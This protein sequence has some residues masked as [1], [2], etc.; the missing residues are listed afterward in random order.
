MAADASEE[1]DEE[2]SYHFPSTTAYL[3]TMAVASSITVLVACY[4]ILSIAQPSTIES[5]IGLPAY[6]VSAGFPT[7]VFSSY[8]IPPAATKEPQPALFDP[9]L[10]ITY[11]LNLTNPDTI[12]TTDDDPIFYPQPIVNVS[13]ATA[14]ALVQAAIA[15]ITAIIQTP[16]LN[17]CTKCQDALAVAKIVAQTTPQSVPNMLVQLCEKFKFASNSSCIN[18][19]AAT[20]YG[21][22]WTQVLAFATVQGLDG[23]YICNHLSSTFCSQP[24][25]LKTNTTDLFPKPKPANATAP[26]PS[27]ERVKVLHLSDFLPAPL[28]GAYRCDTPYYLGLAALQSI[29]PLTGTSCADPFAWTIYTGDLVSHDSQNQLSRAYVEYAEYS[30]YDMFKAYIGSPVFAV[31][32]NHDSNPEAIDAPYSEPDGLG[33]QFSWNY[34]HLAGLWQQNGWINAF[35]ADEARVHYGAYSVKNQYGLRIITLNTDFWYKSNFLNYYNMSNPDVS[36]MQAFLIQELQAAEDAGE[37]VWILGHVLTGWDGTNPLPNPTDLFY[38]IVDRYSPHVIANIFFGHT[39]EDEFM[40]Y[41]ANN[42]SDISSAN[43]LT[44]GWIGPSVTP[45]TNLNS[46]FRMYE[47]DTASFDIYDA[48]TWYANVSSFQTLDPTVTGP[49]YEFEYSTRE[50]YDISWP[51]DAPLNATYWHAVTEAM[52]RNIE[53]VSTFNTLEGKTSINSP[54]CTNAACQ[55]A[56]IC[57]MR[58]GS[59]ALGLSCPKGLRSENHSNHNSLIIIMLQV[60]YI[61]I[62]LGIFLSTTMSQLSSDPAT[63][64][65]PIRILGSGPS[66]ILWTPLPPSSDPQRTKDPLTPRYAGFGIA[67]IARSP[68]PS[69]LANFYITALQIQEK[70]YYTLSENASTVIEHWICDTTPGYPTPL[71][72]T[73]V[74]RGLDDPSSS[75]YAFTGKAL[76]RFVRWLGQVDRQP[77]EWEFFR[78][79]FITVDE[80]ERGGFQR[81]EVARANFTAFRGYGGGGGGGEDAVVA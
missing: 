81:V 11:P 47:V 58:S 74:G 62:A 10:N 46:G 22:I 45:L 19:Y 72:V 1:E 37:R 24:A 73:A 71:N 18:N 28:Y 54:T 14:A 42:A 51:A 43:A 77:R 61:L 16:G 40:I 39:H 15:N 6:T 2:V 75:L 66:Q 25:T 67:Y 55:K 38:Q 65:L 44:T 23:R 27:G 50:T 12:P 41:Y 53:L 63:P 5:S 32:G 13:S 21:A 26:K 29:G 35:T 68:T 48:Y 34:E 36:G 76:V 80:G 64:N 69:P 17:N 8:Y 79:Y 70:I 4:T 9:V 30:I 7:S 56:K 31:L 59:V 33:R 20:N 60:L 78:C 57:Y 49:T 3:V 52:E